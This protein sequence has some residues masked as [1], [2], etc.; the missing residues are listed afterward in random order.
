ME[1]N[2]ARYTAIAS[3]LTSSRLQGRMLQLSSNRVD[4]CVN[5]R[6]DGPTDI[7]RYRVAQCELKTKIVMTKKK[8]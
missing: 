8:E 3:R 1:R 7:V 6:T 5:R 2:K 4:Q